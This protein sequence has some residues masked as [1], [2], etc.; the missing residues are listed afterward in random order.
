MQF[1][2]NTKTSL[3]VSRMK[4]TKMVMLKLAIKR[5][6]RGKL[7]RKKSLRKIKVQRLLL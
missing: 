4:K 1:L 6:G 7:R 5:K 3:G 2:S